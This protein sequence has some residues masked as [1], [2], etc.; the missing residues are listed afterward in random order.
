[1][2]TR[3]RSLYLGYIGKNPLSPRFDRATMRSGHPDQRLTSIL[4]HYIYRNA[5]AT[6]IKEYMHR[7][8]TKP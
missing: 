8:Y 7:L 1:M 3:C 5:M 6:L 4:T 2:Y